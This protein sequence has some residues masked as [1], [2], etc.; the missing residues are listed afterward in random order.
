MLWFLSWRVNILVSRN[1]IRSYVERCMISFKECLKVRNEIY[2]G[3]RGR[4][5]KEYEADM[6]WETIMEIMLMREDRY[7]Y[8]EY[9]WKKRDFK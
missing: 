4:P 2:E 3:K 9:K 5:K 1:E 8:N 6:Q 7:W